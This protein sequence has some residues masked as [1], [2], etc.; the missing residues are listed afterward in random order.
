MMLAGITMRDT[1]LWW[2]PLICGTIL[3]LLWMGSHFHAL[4]SDEVSYHTLAAQLVAGEPYGMPFWPPGWPALLALLYTVFGI[5]PQAG[6]WLNFVLSILTLALT[7]M[8]TARLFGRTAAVWSLWLLALMPS[9]ILPVVL[10]RYEVWLQFLLA[11]GLWASLWMTSSWRW[12]MMAAMVTTLATFVRPLLLPLPLILWLVAHK[13]RGP[14]VRLVHLAAAQ[15]G[16]ILLL[17]PWLWSAS[18]TAG[19]FVPVALNGNNPTATGFYVNPPPGSWDPQKDAQLRAEAI[20]FIREQPLRSAQLLGWKLFYSVNREPW[21]EWVFLATRIPV[22]PALQPLIQTIANVYYWLILAAALGGMALVVGAKRTRLLLP[23]LLL[24]YSIAS[25]LPFFGTPRFRWIVQF[26]LVVYA[27][28]FPVLLRA[29][30][31]EWLSPQ[32]RVANSTPP[33]VH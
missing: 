11:L 5:N 14:R 33:E 28:A 7:G 17:V 20:Q 27:A 30:L 31:D 22:D 21:I 23:L 19:R 12:A 3:R 15:I 32:P 1:L 4:V 26:L 6:L 13:L 24:V 2:L 10:L 16:A 29:R 8:I 25:Q 18:V 9:F